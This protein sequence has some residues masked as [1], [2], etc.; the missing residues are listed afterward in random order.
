MTATDDPEVNRAA[1]EEARAAG[2][3]INAADVPSHCDFIMPSILRRG[4]LSVAISTSGRS[5]ALAVR[6]RQ[7]IARMIG[8]EYARLVE[9]LHEARQ[10]IR[11]RVSDP[12]RRRELQYRLVD[13]DLLELVRH[14]NSEAIR[15]RVE[16][17][18]GEDS[19]PAHASPRGIVYIVGAGPGDP[20]L[21]T[22][23]GLDRLRRAD[24]V[25]HDRLIGSGLLESA[26]PH[27]EVIDVGK[28]AGDQ[29]RMQ[30]FIED[31]MVRRAREGEIVCRLKGGDPF[32][33]GRGGEEARA[34][35]AASI[36]YEIVPGVTSAIAAPAAAGIPLTHRDYAHSFL[37]MTG[38]RAERA[39]PEEW[40]GASELLRVGGTLVVMMGLAHLEAIVERLRSAG[41]PDRTP[42]AIVSRG[43][44][45]DQDVLVGTLATIASSHGGP[46]SPGVVVFG[47]VVREREKLAELARAA[48]GGAESAAGSLN[49]R[50]SPE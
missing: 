5:P 11:E 8:P 37:V 21:I 2:I 48:A 23:R 36:P 6:L 26:S 9:V 28:R 17:A 46:V 4:D 29:G 10:R 44:L 22:V 42:A 7:Q 25:L 30:R 43:T 35:T 38:S 39:R 40:A 18:I 3:W 47:E 33:F 12:G 13:S 24:V 50:I 14:G 32:V 27:A 31:T 1:F 15:A 49:R 19:R 20:G 41:C 45:P 34:L 16:E